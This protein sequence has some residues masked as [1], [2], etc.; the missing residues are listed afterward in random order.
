MFE[1]KLKD[2][3]SPQRF[4]NRLITELPTRLGKK[5]AVADSSDLRRIVSP[6]WTIFATSC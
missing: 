3:L 5:A 1:L 4:A 6:H 2:Q